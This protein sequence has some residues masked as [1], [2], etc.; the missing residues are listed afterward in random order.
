MLSV[1]ALVLF[2]GLLLHVG[3]GSSLWLK[4]WDVLA[5]IV[6]GPM[7]DPS[8]ANNVVWNL[9]LPRAIQC[10][11]VGAI[12]GLVGSAFQAQLR[13][14]LA[15]PYIV[16]VSSGAAVGGV[17]AFITGFATAFGGLGTIV[18]G[19]VTGLAALLL[20]YS[21]AKRRGLV[22]VNTL[23][24]AGVVVGSLL[25]ALLSLALLAAGNDT[26]RV[27]GWLL[28]STSNAAWNQNLILLI[29]CVSG[30]LILIRQSR[31]LNAFAVGEDTAARLGVDVPRLRTLVLTTG[32]AMTAAAVGSVGIIGFLGLVAPHIS[33]R[34]LG[35]DWRWSL[36]GS[37]LA[38]GGLLLLADVLAQRGMS[39]VTG[40]PGMEIPVGIVTAVIGAPSLLLLLRRQG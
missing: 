15:D 12:L 22:D 35:V 5:E 10:L 32:T 36:A 11:L 30:A 20:V 33:R 6:R 26:N 18:A 27:L 39:A 17:L 9:R 37:G 2:L 19:F 4:P 13:N 38:G 25:S 29:A 31:N 3:I 1:L 28:G 24:L 14:P 16:G 23:L 34:L 7:T 21:L 40:T 8:L